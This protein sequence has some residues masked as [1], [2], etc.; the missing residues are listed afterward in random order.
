MSPSA[1]RPVYTSPSGAV[2]RMVTS[3]KASIP[4]VTACTEN[5]VRSLST[6][7]I[8]LTALYTASIGPVPKSHAVTTWSAG[9]R[10]V[11]VAVGLSGKPQEICT[12]SSEYSAASL[13]WLSFM[14]DS[15]SSS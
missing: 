11:T 1:P 2:T 5:S 15:R 12:D 3:P 9:L 8:L 7:T 14:S 10:S 6:C 4:R 13:R